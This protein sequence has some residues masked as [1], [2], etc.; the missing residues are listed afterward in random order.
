M[1]RATWRAVDGFG[2][3]HTLVVVIVVVAVVKVLFDDYAPWVPGMHGTLAR[4]P[5]TS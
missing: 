4:D 2:A 5:S 1:T 3:P